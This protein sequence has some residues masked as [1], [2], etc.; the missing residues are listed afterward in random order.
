MT[1]LLI[2]LNWVRTISIHIIPPNL[3][4]RHIYIVNAHANILYDIGRQCR[5]GIRPLPILG[6][7]Q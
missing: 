3:F 4:T 5:Y 2:V 7:L 6:K 1:L